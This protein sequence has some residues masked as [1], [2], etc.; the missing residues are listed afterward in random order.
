MKEKVFIDTGFWIALFD[1]RD[2]H[3]DAAKTNLKSLLTNFNLFLSDFIVFETLTY[4]NCSIKNH[5]LALRFLDK[6]NTAD[7]ITILDVDT[8]VKNNAIE[9]FKKYCNQ[10]F[11]I[12]D[13]TSFSIMNKA[14]I[15]KYAGFDSHF[16]MID[17]I[18]VL[19]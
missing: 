2:E 9:I 8:S 18:P 4:L 1:R 6:V 17:F 7:A 11:S 19:H 10:Q 12:T 3:H 14:S 15:K 5:N 16:Q 13:C